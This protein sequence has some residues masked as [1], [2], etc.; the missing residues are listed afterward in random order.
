M[1][2]VERWGP[3]RVG[4]AADLAVGGHDH[5]LRGFAG[6]CPNPGAA[7]HLLDPLLHNLGVQRL[8]VAGLQ[9]NVCVEATARAAL[10]RDFEAPCPV[11]RYQPTA[12]CSGSSRLSRLLLGRAGTAPP[13][14]QSRSLALPRTMRWWSR[15]S[16]S[17]RFTRSCVV[18][19]S[20]SP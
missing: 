10:A 12:P 2:R 3:G 11:T 4:L 19:L 15:E 5:G 20:R 1:K 13:A 6:G 18:I 8:V 9:T 14:C 7:G 16:G 17:M